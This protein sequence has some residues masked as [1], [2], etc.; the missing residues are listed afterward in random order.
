LVS[1]PARVLE[2]HVNEKNFVGLSV[3]GGDL[4]ACGSETNEVFV[5]HKSFDRPMVKYGFDDESEREGTRGGGGGAGRG[6][7]RGGRGG[8]DDDSG[9]PSMPA[10]F[11]SATCWRGEEDILLVANS[12]GSI[13]ALQLVEA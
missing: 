12:S 4:I 3:G 5:Y 11:I 13:K 6:G 7:G 1:Q 8:G 10:H 2:G 9:G